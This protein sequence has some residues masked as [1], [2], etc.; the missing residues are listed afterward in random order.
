[1]GTQQ[2]RLLHF[3]AR[4]GAS[5][6]FIAFQLVNAINNNSIYICAVSCY[7]RPLFAHA[8][9]KMEFGLSS[10]RPVELLNWPL[11]FIMLFSL[12]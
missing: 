9:I 2:P 10:S 7:E 12:H 4:F 8:I 6:N 11:I 5:C 1:M 3:A